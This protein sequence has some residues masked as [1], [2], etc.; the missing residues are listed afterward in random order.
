MKDVP[1][2]QVADPVCVEIVGL[3]RP[4]IRMRWLD[5]HVSVFQS[6]ALR[7]HCPCAQ[8]N[9][10]RAGKRLLE[11]K[12][13]AATVVPVG[14]AP[15]GR[16]ALQISW[17]DGHSAGI[18]PFK[19]LRENC[20]CERCQGAFRDEVP[21]EGS[22]SG[23]AAGGPPMSS[24]AR[25]VMPGLLASEAESEP[26]ATPS[27]RE[28]GPKTTM[29]DALALYP[30][31]QRALFQKY[32]IG[33][34]QSC[35]VKPT[36]TL[37]QI[38]Q[39]KNIPL[40]ELLATITGGIAE[41][42]RMEITVSDLQHK[43][44]SGADF[45]LVDVRTQPEWNRGAIVGAQR[46]DDHLVNEIKQRW[47]QDKDIVFYCQHGI[48]SL[49]AASYFAG[50]GYRRVSSLAG[51]YVA[52]LAAQGATFKPESQG[53]GH[54]HP[55]AHGHGGCQGH[56]HSHGHAHHHHGHDHGDH[57]GH[58]HHHHGESCRGGHS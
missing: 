46:L 24:D 10:T 36:D 35:G 28:I 27:S 52:W 33:G 17:S 22:F 20:P 29:A 1:V 53:S 9:D 49:N 45:A 38:C 15:M 4:S 43:I 42:K 5:G 31:A 2:T 3:N 30:A 51:G 26:A 40:A 7:L 54:A 14:M 32:H 11:S 47:A 39:I 58:H 6:F 37:E 16:Y 55:H 48:R 41:D 57:Q 50:H 18:Y 23:E 13:V 44:K 19:L 8:C 21:P 25:Q 12:S 56:D 34:C